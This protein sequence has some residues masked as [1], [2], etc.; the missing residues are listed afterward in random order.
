MF[1]N[2]NIS[3]KITLILENPKS[4]IKKIRYVKE[5][6]KKKKFNDLEYETIFW[7]MVNR[8][9]TYLSKKIFKILINQNKDLIFNLKNEYNQCPLTVLINKK[10]SKDCCS[11]FYPILKQKRL[12]FD[13]FNRTVINYS[14]INYPEFKKDIFNNLKYT[15]KNSYNTFQQNDILIN[16]ILELKCSDNFFDILNFYFNNPI[17]KAEL[18]TIETKNK[19][20]NKIILELTNDEDIRWFLNLDSIEKIFYNNEQFI[21][22]FIKNINFI[23]ER[24]L[25]DI[26]NEKTFKFDELKFYLIHN[27]IDKLSSIEDIS[28]NDFFIKLKKNKT[29]LDSV[30]DNLIIN[31]N[32][33]KCLTL[34]SKIYNEDLK[35]VIL[36][37]F[38]K[39]NKINFQNIQLIINVKYLSQN[40]KKQIFEII[41]ERK[42]YNHFN[43][44]EILGFLSFLNDDSK[45]KKIFN[46]Q[47]KIKNYDIELLLDILVFTKNRTFLL[48]EHN[49]LCKKFII[50]NSLECLSFEN[51]SKFLSLLDSKFDFNLKKNIENFLKKNKNYNLNDVIKFLINQN[52]KNLTDITLET[53][54]ENEQLKYLLNKLELNNFILILLKHKLKKT[55]IEEYFENNKLNYDKLKLILNKI[56][57]NNVDENIY[58]TLKCFSKQN[59]INECSICYEEYKNVKSVW[60][61]NCGHSFCNDCARFFHNSHIHKCAL[62]NQRSN[63]LYLCEPLINSSKNGNDV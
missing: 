20:I 26:F 23:D 31:F 30:L 47:I 37:K 49:E 12:N 17:F 55:I 44:K 39:S 35:S 29:K 21:M 51:F 3:K 1:L 6:L 4:S 42:D 56:H 33:E 40:I 2:Y 61:V 27:K 38:I 34:V 52:K 13:N 54:L 60:L 18:L 45:I 41:C 14:I 11:L 46:E 57:D 9:E 59:N 43:K 5:K 19:L 28:I 16:D 62:C 50:C 58:E 22:F 10:F 24:K 48:N 8:E 7:L 36:K 15:Y 25:V 53:I 32:L 63:R